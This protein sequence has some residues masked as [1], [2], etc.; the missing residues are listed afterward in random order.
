[1]TNLHH[2]PTRQQ[3]IQ[4]LRD[5]PDVSVLIIGGGINGSGLF[6]DLALQG[7]DVV[8]AEKSDFCAGAS[9]ASSHM[10]HGGLR[11]LENGEFR[12]VRE[13]L[14]E[15]NLLLLNAPHY[16]QPLPTLIPIF[17]WM[18][19]AFLA[20]QKFLRLADKPS[21]RG[22]ILIKIGLTLYDI[23][24]FRHR[25]TPT[26][27]FSSRNASLNRQPQLTPDITCTATYYDAWISH[28][29]RLCIELLQ[30][31]EAVNTN[32]RAF[33]YLAATQSDGEKVTLTDQISGE[34]V[35]IKPQIVINATGAWIDF[36]NKSLLLHTEFIGGTKGSHL[37]VDHPQ[38]R[39]ELG[40]HMVLYE[41]ADGRVCVIIPFEDRVL[42]GSTDIYITDP[43]QVR[44]EDSEIDYILESA[45][46]VFPKIEIKREQ[47]VFQFCGVRPLPRSNAAT[48]GKIS[49]DHQCEI[50]PAN[51][52]VKFPVYSLIGG[53][54]T[55][56]RAF[57]EQVADKVLGHFGK[58][59]KINTRNLQIGGGKN[60]PKK[61][62]EREIWIQRVA[63]ETGLSS[64]R[65]GIL[66][67]R[68]GTYAEQFAKDIS[69]RPDSLLK[70][71]PSFS[72]N[73]IEFIVRHEKVT[74]LNDLILRRSNIAMLGNLSY[75]LLEE[76]SLIIA[77]V[78]GWDAE[79]LENEQAQTLA[80]LKRNHGL[81]LEPALVAAATAELASAV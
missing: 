60:Y 81:N 12:L 69:Q 22:A 56:W 29:E 49:R 66:F 23:F 33:N 68:Y 42:I 10:I 8:L 53:K 6:R 9:S 80:L 38:L 65:V 37:V 46:I 3:Q 64:V 15:R 47:I 54:W 61:D 77:G 17:S 41:N 32:A 51:N 31:A 50:L 11:Y 39:R 62:S 16:V 5:R 13:S 67:E 35:E 19:G 71:A 73:E 48:P 36:T 25:V 27:S 40:E 52:Q 2:Q 43:E 57:A 74:R 45:R 78:L 59:R 26:H 1:M 76:I 18:D 79:R 63:R 58:T 28:P 55:T 34:S 21:N 75:E 72:R 70:N 44:C 24:T 14:H 30:E 7:I 4:S 20:V